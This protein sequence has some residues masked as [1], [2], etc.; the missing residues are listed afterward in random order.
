MEQQD[1]NIEALMAELRSVVDGSELATASDALE[2]TTNVFTMLCREFDKVIP[3]SVTGTLAVITTL[4]EEESEQAVEDMLS[5]KAQYLKDTGTTDEDM[6]SGRGT[7]AKVQLI[8]PSVVGTEMLTLLSD[9]EA[10][11]L[12]NAWKSPVSLISR[13]RRNNELLQVMVT[14]STMVFIKTLPSGDTITKRWSSD[15]STPTLEELDNEYEF[16]L[17]KLTYSYLAEPHIIK[18]KSQEAFDLLVASIGHKM[19]RQMREAGIDPDED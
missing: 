9:T 1:P 10:S 4:D 8:A 15:V 11:I 13:V 6:R 3:E 19:E 12:L 5:G 14:A 16:D 2:E 17:I 7:P 18:Q